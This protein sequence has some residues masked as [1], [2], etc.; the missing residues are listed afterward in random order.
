LLTANRTVS[1]DG[2]ATF[3]P[4]LPLE[5]LGNTQIHPERKRELETG[6]ELA[7]WRGRLNVNYNYVDDK[8]IDAIISV[9]IAPS[10]NA[11]PTGGR[12]S[13]YKNVGV[14]RNRVVELSL[15]ARLVETRAVAWTVGGNLSTLKSRVER[16]N[17]GQQTILNGNQRIEAGYPL[18]GVWA[19]PIKSFADRNGDHII[20][21]SEIRYGDSA[22]FV[23]QPDPKYQ[24]SMHTGVTLLNG[25]LGINATVESQE[26]TQYNAGALTSGSFYLLPN[27]PGATLATQAGVTAAQSISQ[28]GLGASDVDGAAVTEIGVIQTVK[29]FRF[30][31]LSINYA[32]PTTITRRLKVPTATL[33]LQGENLGLHTNY[34]GKDPSVNVFATS[35]SAGDQTVDA[36][37]IPLPRGWRLGLTLGN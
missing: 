28:G 6:A 7:L 12:Y 31:S 1:L 25:R 17:P 15:D 35:G 4:A 22:V 27:A 2:G 36:G 8:R 10:I 16:L 24:A 3:V 26:F 5:T 32:L 30:S 9:P 18:W 14:V 19:R 33:F 13:M 11:N 21:P 20:Y 34:R 29:L 37:N 23:G